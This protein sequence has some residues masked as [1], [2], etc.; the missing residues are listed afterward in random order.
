MAEARPINLDLAINRARAASLFERLWAALLWPVLIA[1]GAA[2]LVLSGLLLHL[3]EWARFTALGL[4]GIGFLASLLPL[5]HLRIP[6]RAEGIRRVEERSAFSHRPVA[7]LNDRL[8]SDDPVQATIWEE[9]RLRLL[10]SVKDVKAGAPR[11][12]WRHLDSYALRVPAGLALLAALLLG[13]GDPRSNLAGALES[14]PAAAAP[15][16]VIDAW[17][18]PPAYTAKPPILLTSPAMVE[19]LKSEPEIHVPE[20]AVLTL[21]MTNAS[22][23]ALTLHELGEG[24]GELA[25]AKPRTKFDKGLFQAEV[26]LT[27]PV[28]VKVSDGRSEVA[29]W[30]IDLIPD[31]PPSIS[32]AET[33]AGDGAGTLTTKWKTADDYGVTGL[34]AELS[35]ADEQEGGVG[36]DSNGIFLFD[37]PKMPVSLRRGNAKAEDG[38]TKTDLAEHPWA[39]F[40]AELVLTARDAAGQETNSAPIRFKMPERLFTKPLARALIE[41]RKHLILDPESAEDVG[42]MLDA[43][44]TYPSGLVESSGTHIAVAM[45]MSHLREARGQDD[46]SEAIK[47]L[48]DI[49][50]GIEQGTM[51]NA[52]AELEAL[53][54]ELERA[55]REGASP[56]R[57]AELMEKMRDAMDRYMQSLAEEAQKRLQQ[58]GMDPDQ[59]QQGRMVS[60]QD[61]QKM[62]DMIEKLAQSGANEAAEEL[63]SQLEDI[64]RNLQPG[65][66]QQ[67][68]QQ[69]E[70]PLSQMLDQLSE[71]LK[72]QQQLMDD[73]QRMRQPGDGGEDMDGKDG[74]QEGKSGNGMPQGDLADRQKGVGE[75]LQELLDQLGK[76]GMEAPQSFGDAGK[77]MNGAEGSLRQGDRQGALGQQGDALSKLRE[78]A[79]GLARQMLQQG[80]GQQGSNG[81]H[82]E[83]RGDDRDPLGRPR[84]QRGEDL[85]PD[86]DMLP[87]ELAIRRARE[88]LDMLRSR[89][90]EPGLPRLDRDYIER[91]LRGL[92]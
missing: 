19:R 39:G 77:S 8:A 69:G 89:A 38:A 16:L 56:E 33:P 63:L 44:L 35:L 86:R 54:K 60:P 30:Q 65:M 20:N 43:L 1:A 64:L 12:L 36:F 84:A 83:A 7:G 37:S 82:G 74:Q 46:I 41:Q 10:K 76:N 91:L 15:E 51:A 80:Q 53:R 32:V 67:G 66:P 31:A 27:R 13:P 50:N 58:G 11:S 70:G 23:P 9:H 61:L 34:T 78:G 87:S 26:Q 79:Q 73:T 4:S 47:M 59:M 21:R 68:M 90:N 6:S 29:S 62:L 57:I 88:I 17:L 75:M 49:A 24:G 28:T 18:K 25:G 45:V 85:G 14:S 5:R 40:Y 71:L 92:Y 72:R 22:A 2:A 42:G 55:L 52:K 81:R 48:W 3:P